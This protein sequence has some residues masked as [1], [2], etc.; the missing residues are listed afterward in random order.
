[1]M[2]KHYGFKVM[3]VISVT[4]KFLEHYPDMQDTFRG[5]GVLVILEPDN[6]SVT[7]GDLPV[8]HT[9]VNIVS[10]GVLID[11]LVVGQ[12]LVRNGVPALFF[13]NCIESQVPK[14][15]FIEQSE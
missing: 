15:A 10:N 9:A 11:T 1:M 13:Y 8:V 12:T 14:G 2:S 3:D 7:S 6:P 5:P 4:S